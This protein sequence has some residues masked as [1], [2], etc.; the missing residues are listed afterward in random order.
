MNKEALLEARMQNQN[1]RINRMDDIRYC[2][3]PYTLTLN[4]C[5]GFETIFSDPD[6]IF[7]RVL[8]PDSDPL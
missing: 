1:G 8:Y 2:T 3:V 5:C 6:P 7:I 4:Q